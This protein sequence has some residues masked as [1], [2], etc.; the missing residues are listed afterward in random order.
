MNLGVG[1]TARGCGHG[2]A[3][4]LRV[5]LGCGVDDDISDVGDL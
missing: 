5:L 4:A 1:E 2:P 3:A